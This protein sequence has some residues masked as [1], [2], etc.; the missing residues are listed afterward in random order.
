[1]SLVHVEVFDV[2]PGRAAAPGPKLTFQVSEVTARAI[3]SRRVRAEV[4]VY[5]AAD[6]PH[7]YS[8]LVAPGPV[9]QDLNGRPGARGRRTLD[10]D[11]QIAVALDAVRDRRVIM[12][13]NGVQVGDLDEPLPVTP[14]SE[15]RFIRLV[16][17]VGG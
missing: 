7:T 2:M 1:M 4:E 14:V 13:F 8:G 15:A 6:A 5:N 12:L 9:E 10:G 17:L 3:V 11:R 16:Q